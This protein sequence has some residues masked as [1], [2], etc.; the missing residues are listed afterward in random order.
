MMKIV[1]LALCLFA[2]VFAAEESAPKEKRGLAYATGLGYSA[3]LAYSSG[4]YGGY[5]YGYPGYA[6]YY[7][8]G[9]LGYAAAPLGYGY[10]GY[11]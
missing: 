1:V 6:G 11:Y 8:Y 7:G 10:H 2:A 3:P 4:L 5:G 9:G